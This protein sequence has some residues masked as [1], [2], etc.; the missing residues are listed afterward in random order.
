MF[1]ETL[2]FIRGFFFTGNQLRIFPAAG[3]GGGGQNQP[4]FVIFTTGFWGSMDKLPSKEPAWLAASPYPHFR[5]HQE[6]D[7]LSGPDYQPIPHV[8]LN[9]WAR[10]I[11]GTC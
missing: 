7:Y 9:I 6:V 8:I 10:A 11:S 1:H 5:K 4:S 2:H 3:S